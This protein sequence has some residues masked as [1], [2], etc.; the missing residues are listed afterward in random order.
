MEHALLEHRTIVL[1]REKSSIRARI[2]TLL[3]QLPDS[4]LAKP[5]G[6]IEIEA[7]PDITLLYKQALNTRPELKAL[8]ANI[9]AAKSQS[10]LASI[11][12]YPDI[13]LKAGYNSLWENSS[14]HFTVGIGLTLPLFQAKYRAAENA[15]LAETRQV[16]WQRVDFIAK[17][18][19]DIKISYDRTKESQ[20]VLKL[21]KHKLLPLAEE[22]LEAAQSDYQSGKGGFLSLINSEKNFMLTLLQTEHALAESHRRFA[23]LESAVGLIEPPSTSNL[24]THEIE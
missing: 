10:E 13:S 19:E 3:N 17:L 12:N 6:L 8:T 2:N 14:K 18:R 9:E 20:H 5:A 15:A 23:E 11:N 24:Q 16:E 4:V 7:L 21:Y 1:T 22:T